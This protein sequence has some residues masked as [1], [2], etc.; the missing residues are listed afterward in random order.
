VLQLFIKPAE[1]RAMCAA[2]GLHLTSLQGLVPK[3]TQRAFWRMLRTGIVDDDFECVFTPSTL[4]GYSG[5]AIK[6]ADRRG[7]PA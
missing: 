7:C 2:H 3:I 4:T 6:A 1:L 5:M